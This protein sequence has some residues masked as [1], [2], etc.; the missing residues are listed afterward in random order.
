MKSLTDRIFAACRA[1]A[2]LWVCGLALVGCGKNAEQGAATGQVVA[3]VGKDV[4]TTQELDNEFRLDNIPPDR[5][6]DP[7]VLKQVLN[8]LVL[9]K[10][11]DQQALDA[12]L[13]REP[14]VLLDLLRARSQ[15]LANAYLSRKVASKEISKEDID[16]YIADNPA[17][18]ANRQFLTVEQISFPIGANTQAAV[19]ASKDVKSLDEVE[20]KLAALNVPHNRAMGVLNSAEIP[21]NLLNTIK[22]RKPDD[23]FFA[24]AGPNGLF[25]KVT[26]EEARPLEGEAAREGARQLLRADALKAEIGIAAVAAK[27]EAKYEGEYAATMANQGDSGSGGNNQIMGSFGLVLIL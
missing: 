22:A 1:A 16:K 18:F 3:H 15:V 2:V 26:G 21:D 4:I 20:Q 9:R 25:F 5:Q 23:V 27:L 8:E 10:Y 11:L 13:D 7:A 19:D 12:K 6:K 17:K 24:R 14:R